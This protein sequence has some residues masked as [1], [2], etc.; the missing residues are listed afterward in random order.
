MSV[1]RRLGGPED[2]DAENGHSERHHLLGRDLRHERLRDAGEQHRRDPGRGPRQ[3]ALQGGEAEHLLHVQRADENERVE[4]RAKQET[5]GICSGERL[6][7]EDPQ[8]HQR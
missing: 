7:A 8:R 4:A 2:P 5:D 6:Q 3:A 1:H